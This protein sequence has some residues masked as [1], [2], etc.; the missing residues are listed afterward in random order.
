MATKYFSSKTPPLIVRKPMT[1]R[2]GGRPKSPSKN[3]SS[4][5]KGHK[6]IYANVPSTHENSLPKKTYTQLYNLK[7]PPVDPKEIKKLGNDL[8]KWCADDDSLILEEFAIQEGIAPSHFRRL[9]NKHKYFAECYEFAKAAVAA[10]RERI[11]GKDLFKAMHSYYH[12]DWGSYLDARKEK[13]N[14]KGS[15][16]ITVITQPAERTDIVPDRQ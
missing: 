9:M 3:D 4:F 10:R 6:A 12:E 11:V 13:E 16:S 7:R 1:L 15:Q 14:E 5:K 2:A 8:V